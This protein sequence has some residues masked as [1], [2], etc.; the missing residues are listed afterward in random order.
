M[1]ATSSLAPQY[2]I[3]SYNEYPKTNITHYPEAMIFPPQPAHPTPH[4]RDFS[5]PYP[6]FQTQYLENGVNNGWQFGGVI[7]GIVPEPERFGDLCD[8][9]FVQIVATPTGE[10][11]GRKGAPIQPAITI[12]TEPKSSRC[13]TTFV[14]TQPLMCHS[15]VPS[16]SQSSDFAFPVSEP[17][18]FRPVGPWPSDLEPLTCD[19]ALN[20]LPGSQPISIHGPATQSAIVPSPWDFYRSST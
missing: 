15:A 19:P 5:P 14:T 17:E 12:K 2:Q 11:E 1:A 13:E 9:G 3:G 4:Y 16:C 7:Q 18:S 8:Q 10:V 6:A 20:F